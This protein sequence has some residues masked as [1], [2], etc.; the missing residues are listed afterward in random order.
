M[1]SLLESSS[2]SAGFQ[3]QAR[4][5]AEQRGAGGRMRGERGRGGEGHDCPLSPWESQEGEVCL[6]RYDF[7]KV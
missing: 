5:A 4:T 6:Q 2:S 1:W 3:E 7:H